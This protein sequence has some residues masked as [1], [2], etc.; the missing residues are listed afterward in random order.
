MLGLAPACISAPLKY[1]LLFIL[2]NF[3]NYEKATVI[4]SAVLMKD[5]QIDQWNRPES[6]EMDPHVIFNKGSQ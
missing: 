1:V 2:H 5:K 4:H 3:R 6:S